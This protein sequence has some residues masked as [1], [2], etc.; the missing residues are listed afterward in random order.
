MTSN[1]LNKRNEA[2]PAPHEAGEEPW[3]KD[4][5]YDLFPGS[6]MTNRRAI[7]A[8]ATSRRDEELRMAVEGLRLRLP[9]EDSGWTFREGKDEALDA[10]LALLSPLKDEKEV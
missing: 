10:C 5:K 9:N 1:D 4:K 3:W 2:E 8:E 6:N 7:A